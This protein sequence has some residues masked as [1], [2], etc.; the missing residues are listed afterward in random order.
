[1]VTIGT[2]T[3]LQW[4][5]RHVVVPDDLIVD[6]GEV[7]YLK[8]QPS[9]RILMKL[10]LGARTAGSLTSSP[11]LQQLREGRE[12]AIAKA[13][14][15]ESKERGSGAGDLFTAPKTKKPTKLTSPSL[16]FVMVDGLQI[17]LQPKHKATTDLLVLLEPD[18]LDKVFTK[19]V[20]DCHVM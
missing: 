2:S 5:G 9:N 1:M 19:I 16:D 10:L 6:I 11:G 17:G 15:E 14:K 12:E 20:E 8:V 18:T 4:Q 7:K 3:T 13:M